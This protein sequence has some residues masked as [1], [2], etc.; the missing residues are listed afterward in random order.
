MNKN[1]KY[2]FL[3]FNDIVT[4]SNLLPYYAFASDNKYKSGNKFIFEL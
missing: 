3:K 4:S 2:H 1:E